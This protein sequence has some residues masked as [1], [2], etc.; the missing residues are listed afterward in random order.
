MRWL[1][2]ILLLAVTASA[3]TPIDYAKWQLDD[4]TY[5]AQVGG[6]VHNYYDS[7]AGWSTISN[8]FVVEGDSVVTANDAVLQTRVNKQGVVTVT[9]NYDGVEYTATQEMKGVGWLNTDTRQHLWIDQ[10]MDWSNFTL[11]GNQVRW[12]G[13]TPGV[14]YHVTKSDG[15]VAHA[16]HF[17]PAFLD[18]A[19]V[20][21]DQRADSA[22]IAL[23]N[24]MVYT[25]SGNIDQAD[26]AIGDVDKR[27]LKKLARHTFQLSR[28][29]VRYDS[30]HI[31]TQSVVPVRQYWKRIGGKIY[32]IE[33][34]MMSDLKRIHEAFPSQTIWH[35][36]VTNIVSPDVEDCL[37]N[38]ID[39]NENW[40]AVPNFEVWQPG[41]RI[42]FR[43]IDLDNELGADR[44]SS[45]CSLF[46]YITNTDANNDFV[47]HGVWKIGWVEGVSATANNDACGTA[48]EAASGNCWDI[49]ASYEWGTPGCES[50]NDGGNINYIDNGG[51]DRTSTALSTVT[52]TS[53]DRNSYVAFPMGSWDDNTGNI[54][55]ISVILKDAG[56]DAWFNLTEAGS[57]MPYFAF[58]YTAV[59]A[60]DASHSLTATDITQTTIEIENEYTYDTDSTLDL[61][62]MI[63]D[64]DSDPADPIG[65]E[66]I[67][68]G[69]SNPETLTATS[70][71]ASTQYWIWWIITAGGC[72]P[73]TSDAL[74]VTTLSPP[75]NIKAHYER[76]HLGKGKF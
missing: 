34:V 51:D 39:L 20:L 69:F 66:E 73:D 56:G 41:Q 46:T 37:I 68:T 22:D 64:D 3:Q 72:D 24:L 32:C 26:S 35:N 12:S 17:K 19:V 25:L 53:G 44:S 8:D 27:V 47:I 6:T 48:R 43:A 57:N 58:T 16:I 4:T 9:L 54:D 52:I 74:V 36:T 18:S 29:R 40:G 14:N 13:V 11:A 67:S 65:S 59:T 42:L 5:R 21:Y 75:P 31:R 62:K 71:S 38:T 63:W 50:A 28:Q 45:V 1:I 61:L 70:L 7:T 23:A 10:T 30:S 2:C 33:Y 15:Q 60:C 76:V 49:N 55:T